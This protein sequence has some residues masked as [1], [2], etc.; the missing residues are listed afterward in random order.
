MTVKEKAL[1]RV[2]ELLNY[3]DVDFSNIGFSCGS[4]NEITKIINLDTDEKIILY[5]VKEKDEKFNELYKLITLAWQIELN[6]KDIEKIL[7]R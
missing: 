7:N 5:S 3:E 1:N 2:R 4:R 6:E